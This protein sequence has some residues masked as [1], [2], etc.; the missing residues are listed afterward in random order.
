MNFFSSNNNR[1]NTEESSELTIDLE[2]SLL[3]ESEKKRDVEIP[4]A[5]PVK[6]SDSFKEKK[7]TEDDDDDA[8]VVD[9]D[10][11]TTVIDARCN[12][13]NRTYLVGF[14]IG[15]ILQAC[16]LY[17]LYVDDSIN[18]EAD[19]GAS[20]GDDTSAVAHNLSVPV[21]FVF[22]FFLRYY[23][24]SIALFL[25]PVVCAIS[26]KF[27]CDCCTKDDHN[28]KKKNATKSFLETLFACARFQI[29]LF[30]GSLVLLSIVNF[31]ALAKTAPLCTLLAYYGVC[32]A[33]SFFALSF[34]QLFVNQICADV[35]SVEIIVNYDND[36]ARDKTRPCKL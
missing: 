20:A 10:T 14:L 16:S 32:V 33:I 1:A 6:P 17:A 25:P 22:Y 36:G 29:G 21:V 2:A 13:L 35:S 28:S 15:L 9:V 23:W 11:E 12:L 4:N 5:V 26:R 3:T 31:Y 24:V 30:F 18:G 7:T 8:A 34:L 27:S 19:A